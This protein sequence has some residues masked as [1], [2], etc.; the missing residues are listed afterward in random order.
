MKKTIQPATDPILAPFEFINGF[1]L[2]VYDLGFS[3]LSSESLTKH[4]GIKIQLEHIDYGCTAIVLPPKERGRLTRWLR[5]F[6]KF[7][8]P[9]AARKR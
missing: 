5:K 1:T 8:G 4:T 6:E 9:A 7:D 2:T 3:T